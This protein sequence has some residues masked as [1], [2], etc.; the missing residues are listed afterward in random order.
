MKANNTSPEDRIGLLRS[1]LRISQKEFAKHINITQGALSQI[2][3]KKIH[4][5]IETLYNICERFNISADWLIYGKKSMFRDSVI[6]PANA[7]PATSSHSIILVD[8]NAHADYLKNIENHDYLKSLEAYRIPGFKEGNY[9]MF[10]I[11]GDSMEPVLYDDEI[12]VVERVDNL[13]E[14]ENG[15]ITVLIT[16]EGIVVKRI[17][18]FDN[19]SKEFI[20]QSENKKYKPYRLKKKEILEA[21]QVKAKITSNFLE[22]QPKNEKFDHLEE[23]INRLEDELEKL[24]K[25]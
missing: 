17:Y 2:E 23:R 22:L 20:L 16:K 13:E 7:T 18:P 5:S 6:P 8:I 11:T 10:E 3:N 15:K 4:L 9:R 1:L 14:V 25:N 12:V 21:W 24:K 19:G